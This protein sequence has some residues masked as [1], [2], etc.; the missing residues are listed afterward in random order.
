M[1]LKEIILAV[2]E[3]LA[4]AFAQERKERPRPVESNQRPEPSKPKAENRPPHG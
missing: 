2:V 3:A 1:K 4:R